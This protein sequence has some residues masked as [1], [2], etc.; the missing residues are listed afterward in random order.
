MF[1]AFITSKDQKIALSWINDNER[2]ITAVNIF[3]FNN[4][5]TLNFDNGDEETLTTEIEAV[6]LDVA[7]QND[8]IYVG[9]L[10]LKGNLIREY[11]AKL[12]LIE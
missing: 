7:K 1:G 2:T 11:E 3:L 6:I 12:S 9:S 4:C 10:D 8:V 5:V